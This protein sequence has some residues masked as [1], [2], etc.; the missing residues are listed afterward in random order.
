MEEGLG[1]LDRLSLIDIHVRLWNNPSLDNF[2]L[3][4][5]SLISS[6]GPLTGCHNQT[7]F[8]QQGWGMHKAQSGEEWEG[9]QIDLVRWIFYVGQ[10]VRSFHP[11]CR[12]VLASATLLWRTAIAPSHTL[13][14]NIYIRIQ[15]LV[16]SWLFKLGSKKKQCFGLLLLLCLVDQAT[17]FSGVVGIRW[18]NSSTWPIKKSSINLTYC[19]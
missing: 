9:Y 2:C 19:I 11:E 7:P 13:S 1:Q 6:S 16:S 14:F 3:P 18:R 17:C 15:L 12:L 10:L 5:S 4:L 8:L